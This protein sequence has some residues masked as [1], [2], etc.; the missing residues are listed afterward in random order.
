MTPSDL[1][2]NSRFPHVPAAWLV[3]DDTACGGCP[4]A[5]AAGHETCAGVVPKGPATAEERL[6]AKTLAGLQWVIHRMQLDADGVPGAYNDGYMDNWY[7]YNA[8]GSFNFADSYSYEVVAVSGREI[9][10]QA[11]GNPLD[12]LLYTWRQ[13]D[14]SGTKWVTGYERHG[15]PQPGDV[16][17]LSANSVI[18]NTCW[19]VMTRIKSVDTSTNRIVFE[20]DKA[21]TAALTKYGIKN[22]ETG[23]YEPDLSPVTVK[24]WHHAGNP[25]DWHF[26]IRR[27]YFYGKRRTLV[28]EAADVPEDGLVELA[29]GPVMHP[30]GFDPL[31]ETWSL[32]GRRIDTAA[33]ED[34]GDRN[35]RLYVLPESPARVALK[36]TKPAKGLAAPGSDL[37]ETYNAFKAVYWEKTDGT[38]N[39]RVVG[40]ARCKW[41]IPDTSGS[42]LGD[43]DGRRGGYMCLKRLMDVHSAP[44]DTNSD[45]YA[46][47]TTHSSVAATGVSSFPVS[48]HCLQ[49]GCCD[50]FTPAEDHS[51]GAPFSYA[52]DAGKVLRELV[53]ACD[54][55]LLRLVPRVGGFWAWQAQRVKHPSLLWHAGYYGLDLPN[56]VDDQVARFRGAG[57]WGTNYYTY[58]DDDGNEHLDLVQGGTDG[59]KFDATP[60]GDGVNPS[61]D[62]DGHFAALGAPWK[63]KRDPAA[64]DETMSDRELERLGVAVERGSGE[65][66][67][68]GLAQ[69]SV[70]VAAQDI[71]I[72]A[73]DLAVT[74]RQ[75][76][77]Q[78]SF[79]WDEDGNGI[80]SVL[81]LRQERKDPV[82]LGSRTVASVSPQSDG[83]VRIYLENAEHVYSWINDGPEIG[84]SFD[85]KHSIMAGGGWPIVPL[86]LQSVNSHYEPH[87]IAGSRSNGAWRGDG[88]G[89]GDRRFL[90]K[91][92]VP[93]GGPAAATW[94]DV[95]HDKYDYQV[96]ALW[97]PSEA[98]LALGTSPETYGQMV[99]SGVFNHV[100]S[101]EL[102]AIEE[103]DR[104]VT[105]PAGQYWTDGAAVYVESG[106]GDMLRIE[107]AVDKPKGDG[108]KP[109]SFTEYVTV[110]DGLEM[111]TVIPS[112]DWTTA[113]ATEVRVGGAVVSPVIDTSGTYVVMTF[114]LGEAARMANI[115]LTFNT[116]AAAAQDYY[117]Y[118][119]R[120]TDY[121]LKQDY[122]DAWDDADGKLAA[123]SPGDEVTFWTAAV[124]M[125]PGATLEWTTKTTDA[126]AAVDGAKVEHGGGRGIV[127]A[128]FFADKT[129]SLCWRWRD[130]RLMDHRGIVPAALVDKITMA[131][132]ALQWVRSGLGPGLE[133][134]T[135]S[136]AVQSM[137]EINSSGDILPGST[138]EYEPGG[139][140]NYVQIWSGFNTPPTPPYPGGDAFWG[141]AVNIIS[142][143]F[144]LGNPT[145]NW[146]ILEA[147]AEMSAS[148]ITRQSS[149]SKMGTY[150][151][152]GGGREQTGEST[153]A[154]ENISYAF[155][156][157]DQTGSTFEV[158]ASVPGAGSQQTVVNVTEIMKIMYDHQSDGAYGSFGFI[159]IP[160]GLS[161]TG[162]LNAMMPSMPGVEVVPVCEGGVEHYY[163]GWTDGYSETLTWSNITM[164]NIHMRV[165]IPDEEFEREILMTR[166]PVQA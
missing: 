125:M 19:P 99:I 21:M 3:R 147:Y 139:S 68:R 87:N 67:G 131:T 128:E 7:P 35:A 55:R 2:R 13:R 150:P 25:E 51:P 159:L 85:Q 40:Y 106:I 16:M 94:G 132:H 12:I 62:T 113:D 63:D 164:S 115:T 50:Q 11:A 100:T 52:Y 34:I 36:T 160:D 80:V 73:I 89:V 97:R 103:I 165:K 74:T 144:N 20:T 141:I 136:K 86:P 71:I 47:T 37:T 153:T 33:W 6:N 96:P 43:D 155:I 152:G 119:R 161:S 93:F 76:R 5:A 104:P 22:E 77:G 15:S 110:P 109:G 133:A 23:E 145:A 78:G 84:D 64:P 158:L 65:L 48:G 66:T 91:D 124:A 30:G 118:D 45:G 38:G 28:V 70:A 24:V 53:G 121:A 134:Y 79:E 32:Q 137:A 122:V 151:C 46:D 111:L 72:P 162:D 101:D 17:Q 114:E 116:P 81:P 49:H 14:E 26:I 27:E 31:S 60:D 105:I 75:V 107:Y 108:T 29:A 61:V 140:G 120:Y 154:V 83:I 88:L 126:W 8:R 127:P 123:L 146:T 18:S 102:V 143:S 56:V 58:T 117:S 112:A 98:N 39:C 44:V 157:I 138:T 59:V 142:T 95:R 41:S 135:Y 163:T 90:I 1:P 166:W 10:C 9:T 42:D 54:K 57:L 129:D 4:M 156:G 69:T 82:Q 130:C 149:R 92:V 148:T